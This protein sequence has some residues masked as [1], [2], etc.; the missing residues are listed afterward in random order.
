MPPWPI[1]YAAF[2]G[3]RLPILLFSLFAAAAYAVRRHVITPDAACCYDAA[4]MLFLLLFRCRH[5]AAA[6]AFMMP[7]CRAISLLMPLPCHALMMLR[8]AMPFRYF[9]DYYAADYAS[10]HDMLAPRCHIIA[11]C[12][13]TPPRCF[14]HH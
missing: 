13:A 2:D 8:F 14:C 5:D 3:L 11:C 6:A 7:L 12:Y 9:R 1:R 4:I 10:R